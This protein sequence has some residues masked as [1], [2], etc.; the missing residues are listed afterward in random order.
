MVNRRRKPPIPVISPLSNSDT[1]DDAIADQTNHN[2]NTHYTQ[3]PPQIILSSSTYDI[4]ANNGNNTN[5][6]PVLNTIISHNDEDDDAQSIIS[7]SKIRSSVDQYKRLSIF[8]NEEIDHNNNDTLKNISQV[9]LKPKMK[10]TLKKNL[11]INIPNNHHGDNN[12]RSNRSSI[13]SYQSDSSPVLQTPISFVQNNRSTPSILIDKNNRNSRM[14]E[15]F[16]NALDDALFNSAWMPNKEN[17]LTVPQTKKSKK[18]SNSFELHSNSTL[19]NRYR[20]RNK[21]S[22]SKN[23]SFVDLNNDLENNLHSIPLQNLSPPKI[24]TDNYM[25]HSN[26]DPTINNDFVSNNDKNNNQSFSNT[27]SYSNGS[28]SQSNN[29]T[30]NDDHSNYVTN[31]HRLG[32]FFAKISNLVNSDQVDLSSNIDDDKDKLYNNDNLLKIKTSDN[33]DDESIFSFYINES[34]K[35]LTNSNII[36]DDLDSSNPKLD[37]INIETINKLKGNDTDNDIDT[38]NENT[39]S[40]NSNN[41]YIANP[42]SDNTNNTNNKEKRQ[43]VY[44]H[45]Q[46]LNKEK[47]RNRYSNNTDKINNN[48]TYSDNDNN[49]NHNDNDNDNDNGNNNTDY[50]ELPLY[51]KSLKFFSPDSYIRKFCYL[52]LTYKLI[53]QIFTSMLVVQVGFLAYQQWKVEYGYVYN[54]KYTWIDWILFSFYLMYTVEFIMKVI[55]F[56]F[57]DDSQMIKILK[58]KTYENQLSIFYSKLLKRFKNNRLVKNAS[59]KTK[60]RVHH[61]KDYNNL[62]SKIVGSSKSNEIENGNG[63]GIENGNENEIDYYNSDTNSS[64]NSLSD[65]DKIDIISNLDSKSNNG[66][67]TNLN[68]NVDLKNL[69]YPI[70]YAFLRNG[71]NRVDFIAIICFWISFFLSLNQSDIGKAQVFRSLMCLKI[72]RLLNITKGSRMILRGLKDATL[73]SEQVL[74]FLVCFWILLS[75]IGVESFKSSLRRHCVWTNIN[76]PSDIYVNEFQFCGSYLDPNT[77][78]PLP[79]LDEN[80]LSSGTIKGFTCPAYSKCIMEDNPYNNRVSFDNFAQ[81]LQ[82]VFVIISAN[83]FTDLMYYTMDSD[84]M[85]ASLFYVIS[86]FILTVWLV[87]LVVAVII[88]S[89]KSNEKEYDKKSNWFSKYSEVYNNY[90]MNSKIWNFWNNFDFIFVL[91]IL[92]S[93]IYNCTKGL[94]NDMKKYN[95]CD[96]ISSIILL[97][98]IIIRFCIFMYESN[99]KVFFYSVFNC[100]DLI[101]AIL[102]FAFSIP[103]VYLALGQIVYGWLTFF[104]IIR[105]Y[106]VV[107]SIKVARKAWFLAL[108]RIRPFIELI[109]FGALL[110]FFISI[111]MSRLFEGIVPKSE[112][113]NELWIMY[114][115]PNCIVSLFIIMTTENWTDVLYVAEQYSKNNFTSFCVAIYLISWFILSNTVLLSIFIAII[116]SNLELPQS[117]KRINQIRQFVKSC[118]AK[119]MKNEHEGLVDLFKSNFN[120]DAN[121]IEALGFISHMNELLVSNGHDPIDIN[122]YNNDEDLIMRN[123]RHAHKTFSKIP[124]YEYSINYIKSLGSNIKNIFKKKPKKGNNSSDGE[125]DEL[126][127]FN[128]D[129]RIYPKSN[130]K[131]KVDRSLL[132]FTN[133]NLLRQFCQKFVEPVYMKRTQGKQPDLRLMY[134]FNIFLFISSVAVVIL[135][136]Y[137]TPLYRR[138]TGINGGYINWVTVTDL[139]FMVIFTIEFAVKIIADGFVFGPR[140]Y[141]KSTWNILDFIVLISFWFTVFSVITSNYSLLVTFNAL[142]ALRAFRLLTI[143]K[144]SQMVFH[145]AVISGAVKILSAAIVSLSLLI[146]FSLWGLN[147]F[148]TDLS[149]CADG[150][151]LT[152]NCSLEFK[153]EVFKWEILSPNYIETPHLHFSTFGSS[154]QS[155][156]EILSLEGWVDLL[157]NVVNISGKGKPPELFASTQNGIFI[158]L[159]IFCA[160]VFIINLFISIIIN[161]YSLQTGTAFLNEDQNGWYE[162]KKVLSKVEPSRRREEFEMNAI[163]KKIYKMLTK[164]HGLWK[165][166]INTILLLHF[167]L[168][169]SE[170]YPYSVKGDIVRYSLFLCTTVSLFIHMLLVQYA[171]G[172]RIFYS[173]KWNSIMMF[174]ISAAVVMTCVSLG[175]TTRTVFTNIYKAFL[176]AILCLVIPQVDILNQ[177]LKYGSTA[178]FPLISLI[179]TWLV[180]FLV[181]AIALNQFFGLTRLGENTT[182]NL[183]A[184]TVTKALIMLF[185]NSFGEGWNDIMVDFEVRAPYC[186]DNG[187]GDSDCGNKSFA[188]LLFI[189][190]NIL[191]MYIFLNILVSV[192]INNFSYVY[193]GSGPHNLI[194]REEIRKFKFAWNKFDK[195]GTGYIYESDLHKFLHSLDGVLSYQVYPKY[196]SL[197]TILKKTII[198]NDPNNGYDIECNLAKLEDILSIVDFNKIRSRRIRYN[199]LVSELLLSSIEVGVDDLS[200]NPTIIRRIPF[201]DTILI[202]GYYSRFEDSTCLNLEDFLR[203]STQIKAINRELRKD[204]IVSTIKMIFTRLRYKYAL[205]KLNIL[206]KLKLKSPMEQER[207]KEELRTSLK[208]ADISYDI[209]MNYGQEEG[210]DPSNPIYNDNLYR[211]MSAS[212]RNPFSDAYE[213]HQ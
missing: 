204:K 148:G 3:P 9:H 166:F 112:M 77:L 67:K 186:Y 64:S 92:V 162:V 41:Y 10:D 131:I 113:E 195:F 32:N 17:K 103:S 130:K 200:L 171:L 140:A 44:S 91:T 48:D 151:S 119:V 26:S 167:C 139:V 157:S 61:N 23:S 19:R 52:V 160:V 76:D 161:N 94:S 25:E 182:G 183:N 16:N 144:E 60:N 114:N 49:D 202:V 193:H 6:V 36:Y 34:E 24:F 191:S 142:R 117:E 85:V 110:L 121:T 100:I 90:V 164:K 123:L 73:Q 57:Y 87:N 128:D 78:K 189:C 46:K 70:H 65:D 146:P 175:I 99:F 116:T 104:S 71:W 176:V 33:L 185:R 198:Q 181:F 80:H 106:R 120:R 147:I 89:Y 97:V 137:V 18:N 28:D 109:I 63:N 180:L 79:Y 169:I 62:N 158:M 4:P 196:L 22:N 13:S 192:V 95:L 50:N 125:L 56:G 83:T 141:V 213:M 45:T 159:F 47:T 12:S 156:F 35:R 207:I 27:L 203:H 211:V 153:N 154:F 72:F 212:S 105:F 14:S 51:G 134:S 124:Y 132:V 210:Y 209:L 138:E 122:N 170:S 179:Y 20:P 55:A 187:F 168:L 118:V 59:F 197:S 1:D 163:Q 93:F 82:S 206:D 2:D 66:S 5:R 68:T 96:F 75:I 108:K 7:N 173:N 126:N 15:D 42:F 201:K 40:N 54:G 39:N 107:K 88:H 53:N 129:N 31:T 155:L 143:T 37:D 38:D 98:E 101:T 174:V 30:K 136:C 135:A 165:K 133:E 190:W 58:L 184:R 69:K 102:A 29:V 150:V 74:I 43:S 178:L 149:Y 194:T 177:L 152:S 84:A 86:I 145:I 21:S 111:V 208:G 115:L 127:P 172:F 205:D 199:R 8:S 188:L 81:S 11:K